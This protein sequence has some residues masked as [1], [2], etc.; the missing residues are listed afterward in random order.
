MKGTL[1]LG[2]AGGHFYLVHMCVPVRAKPPRTLPVN[3]CKNQAA[4]L[5]MNVTKASAVTMFSCFLSG[6]ED[7]REL[8]ME[9]SINSTLSE[10]HQVW[11]SS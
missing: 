11:F 3:L 8:D 10:L 6:N 4:V 1:G 9:D 7:S 5:S 2:F